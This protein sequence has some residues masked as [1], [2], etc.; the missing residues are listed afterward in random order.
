MP[1]LHPLPNVPYGP[2]LAT[3]AP[4]PTPCRSLNMDS[5]DADENAVTDS[6]L[7]MQ[8]SA[9]AVYGNLSAQWTALV[10]KALR[11]IFYP[12]LMRFPTCDL[13][14]LYIGRARLAAVGMALVQNAMARLGQEWV[15]EIGMEE[16]FSECPGSAPRSLRAGHP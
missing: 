5:L 8:S 11:P 16:A 3:Y 12:L 2:P 15:D 13:R 10:P 4:R 1:T 7:L 6:K 9:L 14:R